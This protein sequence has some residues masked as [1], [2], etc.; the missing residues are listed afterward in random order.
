MGDYSNLSVFR[1]L[2]HSCSCTTP[3]WWRILGVDNICRIN[4][5]SLTSKLCVTE[6]IVMYISMLITWKV[7]QICLKNC[8]IRSTWTNNSEKIKAKTYSVFIFKETYQVPHRKGPF[9][10]YVL[11]WWRVEENVTSSIFQNNFTKLQFR[12]RHCR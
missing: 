1:F 8:C 11:F 9:M 6:N 10:K 4:K 3:W 2:M 12:F 7:S 5:H